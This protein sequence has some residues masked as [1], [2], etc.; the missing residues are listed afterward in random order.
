MLR[1]LVGSEMCI[2]DRKK[3]YEASWENSDSSSSD[4][5]ETTERVNLCYM[6]LEDDEVSFTELSDAFHELFKMKENETIS[7]MVTRFTDITNSLASLGKD[8][9]QVERIRKILRALTPE[10][11]RRQP[12]LK[13]RMISQL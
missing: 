6:A 5:E 10:W 4:E 3:I 9:T 2:R 12:L 13:R 8:Y 1:S 11:R 7:E